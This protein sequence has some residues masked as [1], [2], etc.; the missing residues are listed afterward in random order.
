MSQQKIGETAQ[1]FQAY[2][3]FIDIGDDFE[4]IILSKLV[5]E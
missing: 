4:T 5:T 2:I 1:K 3:N